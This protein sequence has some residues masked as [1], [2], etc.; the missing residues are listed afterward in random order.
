MKIAFIAAGILVGLI[1]VPIAIGAML[2]EKHRASR[3]AIFNA[4]PER[5]FSLITGPQDWRHD[6]RSVERGV[7]ANGQAWVRE[8]T[9]RGDTVTY[10]VIDFDPP[11]RYVARIADKKLPYGGQWTYQIEP[12]GS[13]TQLRI[14]ED[15]EVYNPIF[16]FVSKFVIGHTETIDKYLRDIA[17]QTGDSI[18]ILNESE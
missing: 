1:V 4:S 18:T 16:R 5:L 15:G 11:R 8:T 9:K 10:E 6:L 7:D 17:S 2:P 14:V 13:Q 3:S 12:R